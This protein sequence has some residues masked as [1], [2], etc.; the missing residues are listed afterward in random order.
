MRNF[1]NFQV[2]PFGSHIGST[3]GVEKVFRKPAECV[4]NSFTLLKIEEK[5]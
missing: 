3:E 1:F 2:E 5:K 4:E